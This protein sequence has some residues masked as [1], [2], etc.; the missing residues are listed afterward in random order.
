MHVL[1]ANLKL[2]QKTIAVS[3]YLV[4]PRLRLHSCRLRNLEDPWR[5][6]KTLDLNKTD[7]ENKSSM[8]SSEI[9][10]CR[11]SIDNTYRTVLS[12]VEESSTV[13]SP[14][15]CILCLCASSV[16]AWSACVH[17]Q[18][19]LIRFVSVSLHLLS[20]ISYAGVRMAGAGIHVNARQLEYQGGVKRFP[21]PDDKVSWSVEWPEYQPV[22]YTAPVVLKGPVWADPDFRCGAVTVCRWR[23]TLG[24]TNVWSKTT[25]TFRLGAFP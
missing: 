1:Y 20:G 18:S 3:F 12:M 16:L 25:P 5:E 19:K 15:H 6:M 10:G 2:Y 8:A 4:F 21:V 22:D 23:C 13:T 11:W 9:G 7:D 14:T 17:M 24:P